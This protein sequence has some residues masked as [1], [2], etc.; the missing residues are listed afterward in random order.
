VLALLALLPILLLVGLLAGA[1]WSAA[2]A[3]LT[4]A[5]A[6]AAVAAFG[7]GYG[8]SAADWLGPLL[9]AGF[10][11]GTI[12]WI[13]FGALCI[14]EYQTKSGGVA[15]LGRW[16]SSFGEDRRVTALFIAWFF[17]F[18]WKARLVL[19]LLSRL[20]RHCWSASVFRRHG[21]SPWCWSAMRR[22]SPSELSE[23]L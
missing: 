5:A 13:I 6:A 10:I 21:H 23:L 3:G 8:A 9:E 22:E 7:F 14:H 11:A 18:S 20:R 16:L 15:V 17:A 1:R 2:H 19:A 12:L 4:S